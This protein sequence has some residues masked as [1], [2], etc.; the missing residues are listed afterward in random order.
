MDDKNKGINFSNYQAIC[1]CPF[2]SI[3]NNDLL[4]E[5]IDQ[6]I[7]DFIKT[8]NIKVVICY[9]NV[10]KYEYFKKNYG[11]MILLALILIQIYFNILYNFKDS[12][13]IK[14]FTFRLIYSFIFFIHN[15]KKNKK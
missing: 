10:I 14:R 13:E 4:N 15:K 3:I 8:T 7:L 12:I 9:E 6:E 1:E 2:S 5:F 11:S